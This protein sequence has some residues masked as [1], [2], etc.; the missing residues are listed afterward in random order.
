MTEAG[1]E[2]PAQLATALDENQHIAAEAAQNLYKDT[3]DTLQNTF[4]A[5]FDVETTV[6][7]NMI[8]QTTGAPTDAVWPTS[9]TLRDQLKVGHKD[10]GIFDTPHIAWFAENGPEAAIP[11]DGSQNAISLW[12]ETGKLL[13][14]TQSTADQGRTI[15]AM[16]HEIE[17]T[18]TSTYEGGPITYAPTLQFNGAAPSKAD[19]DEALQMSEE[20]F[21][22]MLE[23]YMRRNARLSFAQ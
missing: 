17:K 8:P 2:I 19:L 23:S 16:S 15:T 18:S 20:R 10:G 3:D 21:A 12:E 6:R 1:G 11:L 9:T 22:E 5:G 4:A 13:G 14:Q 7:M